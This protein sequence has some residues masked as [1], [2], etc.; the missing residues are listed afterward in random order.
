MGGFAGKIYANEADEQKHRLAF[1]AVHQIVLEH[2]EEHKRGKKSFTMEINRFA[3][4]V[5]QKRVL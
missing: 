5:R 3:D 1:I 4:Y 2:N